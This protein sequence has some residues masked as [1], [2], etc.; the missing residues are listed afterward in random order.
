MHIYGVG[1]DDPDDSFQIQ[2]ILW[3]FYYHDNEQKL[4]HLI[5]SRWDIMYCNNMIA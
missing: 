4:C 1:L 5:K 2:H 3:L